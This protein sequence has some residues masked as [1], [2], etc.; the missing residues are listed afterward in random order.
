M[1]L[2]ASGI[3]SFVEKELSAVL[4][5]HTATSLAVK[6]ANCL[7]LK[8]NKRSPHSVDPR[9]VH[10]QKMII[11]RIV[12]QCSS[13]RGILWHSST[14]SLLTENIYRSP[15]ITIRMDTCESIYPRCSECNPHHR[16]WFVL[17]RPNPNA[18]LI[19]H[20]TDVCRPPAHDEVTCIGEH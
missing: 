16:H 14:A 18:N 17:C 1:S 3:T 4:S 7:D 19:L 11:A 8:R 12:R 10:N 20:S 2:W 6:V 15:M 9:Y 13:L 5:K